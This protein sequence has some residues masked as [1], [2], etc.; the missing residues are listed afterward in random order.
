MVDLADMKKY[1][2]QQSMFKINQHTLHICDKT[3][4]FCIYLKNARIYDIDND[5]FVSN[6]ELYQVDY[7]GLKINPKLPVDQI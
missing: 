5:G 4:M 1:K 2:D 6:G 3:F 7:Y